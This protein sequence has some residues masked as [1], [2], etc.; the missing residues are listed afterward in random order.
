MNAL[1]STAVAPITLP[2][3]PAHQARSHNNPATPCIPHNVS[4][5]PQKALSDYRVN[6]TTTQQKELQSIHSVTLKDGSHV[7]DFT[8]D[9]HFIDHLIT[10]GPA[11]VNELKRLINQHP[12][13]FPMPCMAITAGMIKTDLERVRNSYSLLPGEDRALLNLKRELEALSPGYPYQPS[14]I[15]TYKYL[16]YRSLLYFRERLSIGDQA[17][18]HDIQFK[19]GRHRLYDFFESIGANLLSLYKKNCSLRDLER[20][21]W[22]TLFENTDQF[23]MLLKEQHYSRVLDLGAKSGLCRNTPVIPYPQELSIEDI[24]RVWP[25]SL[26]LAGFS[27]SEFSQADGFDMYPVTFFEHDL[28]HLNAKHLSKLTTESAYETLFQWT[29]QLYENRDQI[30]SVNFKAIELA[31]FYLCHE[32]VYFNGH[33][34]SPDGSSFGK[35]HK[36]AYRISFKGL[37]KQYWEVTHAEAQQACLWLQKL[38][39]R[40]FTDDEFSDRIASIEETFVKDPGIKSTR[41]LHESKITLPYLHDL[42]L[43]VSRHRQV[44]AEHGLTH[45]DVISSLLNFQQKASPAELEKPLDKETWLKYN[46][47]FSKHGDW[48]IGYLKNL[49]LNGVWRCRAACNALKK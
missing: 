35:I 7:P 26:W 32:I 44:V 15:A 19:P 49:H 17:I 25:L 33:T 20:L 42:I 22:P 24:N 37:P 6:D 38:P 3:E 43:E 45:S 13:E 9:E 28:Y 34:Y 27:L 12:N 31:L 18:D 2:S 4:H 8:T 11:K 21:P 30:K 47:A 36:F 39:L 10:L 46:P 29:R 16:H 40:A 41:S 48:V 5:T 1:P 14:L 23:M